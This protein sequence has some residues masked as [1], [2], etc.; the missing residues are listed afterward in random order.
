MIFKVEKRRF[1]QRGVLRSTRCYY[2][3]Y[4]LG[5][6]P[7][8]RW[9]SLGVTDKQVA[10]KK[11]Q[12]FRQEH[13]REAAGILEPK[14]IRKAATRPFAAHLEDYPGDLEKRNRAGRNG[15]GA[16]QL[17]MRVGTLLKECNWTVA[18]NVTA[19]SFIAWRT[20]QKNRRVHS[21]T[22]CKQWFL[23]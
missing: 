20:D 18:F 22:I 23:S 13:E 3:R 7:A 1:R 14:V 12:E 6:M 19:D 21:T 15:R 4:R 16:R 17:K 10:D 5:D 2:L 8:D 9:K 11:A